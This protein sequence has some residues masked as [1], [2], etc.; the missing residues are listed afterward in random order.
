MRNIL[1][2]CAAAALIA[3]GG[4]TDVTYG[5]EGPTSGQDEA[6]TDY[7]KGDYGYD[8]GKI[9]PNVAFLGWEH[10]DPMTLV[11]VAEPM[12][13]VRMSDFYDP[14][15]ARGL[16]FLVVTVQV[17]WCEPSN[18]QDDFTNGANYTG[19][20]T[21]A[22]NFATQY[23][24]AGVRF[25]TL[26]EEGPVFGVDATLDDLRGWVTH[27]AAR[28]SQ[29]LVS[30]DEMAIDVVGPVWPYNVIVDLR[31]MRIVATWIG[32]DI[33]NKTLNALIESRGRDERR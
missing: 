11:D 9:V 30:S 15:G 18:E 20:N 22:A 28:T 19:A 8:V 21:A 31:T 7:P 23:A 29:A 25:M 12:G 33:G 1:F 4:R 24:P 13:K 5:L 26:L 10:V 16:S 14:S 32:F 3:C 27:H 6:T 17:V 2:G